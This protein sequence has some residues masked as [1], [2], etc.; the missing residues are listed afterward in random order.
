MDVIKLWSEV[1]PQHKDRVETAW[2]KMEPAWDI[3]REFRDRAGFHAD[4]PL[5]FFRARY[6]VRSEFEQVYA[7]LK[8]FVELL[9]FFLKIEASELP[10]LEAELDN[11]LDD[12]EKDH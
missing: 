8:E 5:K 12:L 7:A 6:K 11:L 4:R 3:L 1:F 9:K 10:G 2:K